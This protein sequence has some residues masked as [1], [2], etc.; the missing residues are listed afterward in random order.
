MGQGPTSVIASSELGLKGF[1]SS[2]WRAWAGVCHAPILHPPK[3]LQYLYNLPF[4]SFDSRD[5]WL[6]SIAPGRDVCSGTKSAQRK[7]SSVLVLDSTR[8]RERE[9]E[10]A[11]ERY[12]FKCALNPMRVATIVTYT[13]VTNCLS[14]DR[15]RFDR[16]LRQKEKVIILYPSMT[17]FIWSGF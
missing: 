16:I 4:V 12:N 2:D 11:W 1:C 14:A 5:S 8:E 13:Y 15:E 3:V 7:L 17:L 10:R 6:V 9:R